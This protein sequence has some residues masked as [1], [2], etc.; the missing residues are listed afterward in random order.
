[1]ISGVLDRNEEKIVPSNT[2]QPACRT[3]ED[4]RSSESN[5]KTSIG[6][7]AQMTTTGWQSRIAAGIDTPEIDW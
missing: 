6:E 2:P 5:T 1:L 3:T 7:N 4:S